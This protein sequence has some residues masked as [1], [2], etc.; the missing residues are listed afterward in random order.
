M[1]FK[2]GVVKALSVVSLAAACMACQPVYVQGGGGGGYG[3]G[4]AMG[5]QTAPTSGIWHSDIR[6]RIERAK[7]WIDNGEARGTLTLFEVSRLRKELNVIIQQVEGFQSD[8]K[9]LSN[10]DRE[11]I[12]NSLVHLERAIYKESYDDQYRKR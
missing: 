2:F 5:P 1:R 6:A 7:S 10:K 8:D 3:G 4:P 12:H 9:R 11:Q